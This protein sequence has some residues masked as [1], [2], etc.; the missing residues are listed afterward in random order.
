MKIIKLK[1]FQ[2]FYFINGRPV[3]GALAEDINK[4][5]I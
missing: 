3:A 4:M 5:K 2:P 1:C